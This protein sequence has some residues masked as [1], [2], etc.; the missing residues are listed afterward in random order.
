MEQVIA[1]APPAAATQQGHQAATTPVAPSTLSAFG[2]LLQVF[3]RELAEAR[4]GPFEKTDALWNAMADVKRQLEQFPAV[5]RR[6]NLLVDISV[7][8]GNWA[9]VPWIALLNTKVQRRPKRGCMLSF[10]LQLGWIAFLTLNQGAT[11]LVRGL[12]QRE[13]QKQMM[14]VAGKMRPLVSELEANGFALDNDIKLGS[15]TWRPKNYEI[16][17]I[18]HMKFDLKEVPNDEKMNELL[19]AVLSAYDRAVR[20]S[21]RDANCRRNERIIPPKPRTL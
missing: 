12:G 8:Q 15:D 3:L 21:S 18:A 10:L 2:D 17:A 1:D 5:H 6:P 16:G 19:E 13:A 4:S 7:G 14:D 9:D 20:L 11:K